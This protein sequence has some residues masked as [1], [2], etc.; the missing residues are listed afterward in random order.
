MINV[1]SLSTFLGVRHAFPPY[2]GSKE[3]LRGRLTGVWPFTVKP[4]LNGHPLLSGKLSIYRNLLPIFTV[5]LTSIQ[6]SP[7]LSGRGHRFDFPNG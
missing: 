5:N 3:R 4:L 2:E 7:L 1:S 6:R